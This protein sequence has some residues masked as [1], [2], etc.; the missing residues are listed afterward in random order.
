MKNENK[1]DAIIAA[2]NVL[3]DTFAPAVDQNNSAKR[4][5]TPQVAAAINELTGTIV[6]EDFVYEIMKSMD[7]LYVVDETSTRLK[8]VWLLNYR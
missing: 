4:F 8:Y 6:R 2:I 5:T 7:Y 1:D 3:S